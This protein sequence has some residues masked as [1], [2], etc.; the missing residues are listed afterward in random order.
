VTG[1][2]L[3][4]VIAARAIKPSALSLTSSAEEFEGPPP[5][6]PAVN[7][8]PQS[9]VPACTAA[10]FLGLGSRVL[11]AAMA[12]SRA[13]EPFKPRYSLPSDD[14]LVAEHLS[15]HLSEHDTTAATTAPGHG[16]GA[17]LQPPPLVGEMSAEQRAE[18]EA[19]LRRKID[20]RLLPTITLMYVM[21]YL[22][23]NNIAAVR[24]AGLQDEL[25]LASWQYQVSADGNGGLG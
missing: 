6:F 23:R 15:E 21:N 10:P 3:S 14:K 9:T 7:C 4:H 25:N 20:T 2:C 16:R 13:H 22:D 5:A 19:R 17:K 1:W 24:L 11:V 18:A 8:H 12:S